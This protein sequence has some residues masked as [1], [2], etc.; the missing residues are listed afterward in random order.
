MF[1]NYVTVISDRKWKDTICMTVLVNP[2][3]NWGEKISVM[4]G[5]LALCAVVIWNFDWFGQVLIECTMH[6]I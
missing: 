6:N 1:L 2:H 3:S 4:V 5:K